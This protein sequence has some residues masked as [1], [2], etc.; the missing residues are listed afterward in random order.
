LIVLNTKVQIID[1]KY[2]NRKKRRN[3][4]WKEYEEYWKELDLARTK[5]IINWKKRRRRINTIISLLKIFIRE[6]KWEFNSGFVWSVINRNI[7]EELYLW[8]R[9]RLKEF[10]IGREIICD[11]K[12]KYRLD[13]LLKSNGRVGS[14][15]KDH[16]RGLPSGSDVMHKFQN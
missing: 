12:E 4:R 15:L 6:K 5:L 2:V 13:Q 11:V 3:G 14:I 9:C 7:I 8:R 1:K 16:N 10:L